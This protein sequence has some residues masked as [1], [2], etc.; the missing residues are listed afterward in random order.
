MTTTLEIPLALRLDGFRY[1][2]I[3]ALGAGWRAFRQRRR[4][5]RTLIEISRLGPRVIR[6]IGL[7]PEQVYEA[8]DG[9]WDEMEPLRLRW[10]LPRASRV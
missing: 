9:S 7:D 10:L 4:E 6:D 5:R 1:D 3:G 8:L 2:F